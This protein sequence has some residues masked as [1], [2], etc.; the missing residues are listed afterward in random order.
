M[1]HVI[2]V[3]TTVLTDRSQGGTSMKSGEIEVMLH[4]RLLHDDGFGVG[5]PLNETAFGTGLV[6]RGTHVVQVNIL[7][8]YFIEVRPTCI[9]SLGLQVAS[10]LK[11][12]G[13]R[14]RLGAQQM[15]MDAEITFAPTTMSW[16][17]YRKSHMT[18]RSVLGK[19]AK[20][21]ENVH[22][23]TL[24]RWGNW[25]DRVSRTIFLCMAQF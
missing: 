24:E 20:V 2:L 22:M 11:T 8:S 16:E 17:D 10:D 25:E 15:F 7:S 3:Q 23:L 5:E 1:C 6:V 18:E 21:T 4:R 19:E 9:L 13:R 12:A 14:H